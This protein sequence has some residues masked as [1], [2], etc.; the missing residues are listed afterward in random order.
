[1]GSFSN[2]VVLKPFKVVHKRSW[3]TQR[4]YLE[5]RW[6]CCE[7]GLMKNAGPDSEDHSAE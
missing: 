7:S 4:Y 2:H 1:M 3:E 5:E 6:E